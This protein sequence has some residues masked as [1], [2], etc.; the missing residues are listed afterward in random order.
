MSTPTSLPS[1]D[2]LLEAVIG[3]CGGL[4]AHSEEVSLLS[5]EQGGEGQWIWGQVP[6]W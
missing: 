4:G 2:L 1:S 6:A 3:G 5:G